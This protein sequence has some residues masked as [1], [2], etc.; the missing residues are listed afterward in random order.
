MSYLSQYVSPEPF[1]SQTCSKDL[2]EASG[3][4]RMSVAQIEDCECALKN[5]K[6]ENHKLPFSRMPA[7]F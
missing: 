6:P 3:K 2:E 4:K 1:N 5:H 7:H